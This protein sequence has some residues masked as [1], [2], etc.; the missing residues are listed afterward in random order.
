MNPRTLPLLCLSLLPYFSLSADTSQVPADGHFEAQAQPKRPSGP[1]LPIQN[2]QEILEQFSEAYTK[3][4]KP[5]LLLYVNRRL[6]NEQGE[7]LEVASLNTSTQIKGDSVPLPSTT[8]QVGSDNQSNPGPAT[9][10]GQGGER[11][12]TTSLSVRTGTERPLGVSPVTESEAR[13]IEEAFQKSFFE[14]RARLVDQSIASLALRPLEKTGE[15]FLTPV[16][17]DQESRELASL[18][19]S[20]DIVIEILAR[21]QKVRLAQPS[22]NDLIEDRISL[23]ATATQL[24]DGIKLA[25]I[26]SDTLFGFNERQGERNER[27]FRE[28]S[29]QEILDQTA[30]ALMQRLEF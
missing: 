9:P 8:V 13:A 26:S 24:K 29:R 11:R 25:Q 1:A 10:S 27:R 21:N 5:R 3:A 18:R 7:L 4:G 15:N 17:V 6:L 2:P 22:G 30:L 23:I 28:V 12:E 14:A 16:K 20:T 19:Q